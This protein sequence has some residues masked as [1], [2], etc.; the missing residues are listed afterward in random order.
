[1]KISVCVVQPL[2]QINIGYIARVMKNFGVKSLYLLKPRCN[3]LGSKAI[4]YSKHARSV[5]ENAKIVES[6]DEARRASRSNIVVGTT[7][8]W[9]KSSQAFYNV[10]NPRDFAKHNKS[11]NVLIVLGRDDTGL[12]H[13]EI[14]SCDANVFIETDSTYPV[15]NISHALAILLYEFTRAKI[16]R[17]YN[18]ES[19][20][21]SA[22]TKDV[23]IKLFSKVVEENTQIRDKKAVKMAFKHVIN[24]SMPTE[25]ELRALMI[26][27]HK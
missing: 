10:Q 15:L 3:Y 16:S 26:A 13:N 6:I 20:K 27:L 24:R 19:F 7:G 8:I 23:I 22:R 25:K 4:M 18:F 12:T 17:Q 11:K 21:S 9:Q 1:M 2:Y 14:M 5:I